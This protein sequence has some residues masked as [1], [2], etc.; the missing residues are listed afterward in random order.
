L[1]KRWGSLRRYDVQKSGHCAKKAKRKTK[2]CIAECAA[3]ACWVKDGDLRLHRNE[4]RHSFGERLERLPRIVAPV[5]SFC[6]E[7][8]RRFAK[9]QKMPSR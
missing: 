5:K 7:T 1:T 6:G 2:D 8:G 9:K 3:D 4:I